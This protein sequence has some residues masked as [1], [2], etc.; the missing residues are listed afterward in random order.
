M[1]KELEDLWVNYFI[2]MPIE[3]NKQE[4]EIIKMWSE[5]EKLLLSK[6]NSEQKELLNEYD[7]YVCKTNGISEK[8]AFIKG[9]RFATRLFFEAL[10]DD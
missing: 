10:C 2:E 5:K 9:V 6:L 1:R 7:N 4:K 3:R 8:Y